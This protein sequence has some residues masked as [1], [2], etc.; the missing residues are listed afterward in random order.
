MT[1]DIG[2]ETSSETESD[3]NWSIWKRKTKNPKNNKLLKFIVT[4]RH[5]DTL[6]NQFHFNYVIFIHRQKKTINK[7]I[8]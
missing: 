3:S 5:L 1:E 7:N 2:L 8:V 4:T 6:L